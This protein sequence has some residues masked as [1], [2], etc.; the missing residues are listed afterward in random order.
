MV[1]SVSSLVGRTGV[2]YPSIAR[3]SHH[4]VIGALENLAGVALYRFLAALVR[5]D[6]VA[7]AVQGLRRTYMHRRKKNVASQLPPVGQR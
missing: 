3:C 2:R 4:W 6:V 1:N 5:H 7:G